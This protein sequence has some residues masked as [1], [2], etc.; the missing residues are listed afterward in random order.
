[1]E[2]S[3][4]YGIDL[5]T[6]HSC[7]S[8]VD[9]ASGRPTVAANAEGEL[10]TPSVVLFEDEETRV[11]GREAKNS[12]TL[13]ADRVVEMVKRQMGVPDWRF[14]FGD[15][16]FS[17]EEISSYI[18]RKVA[19]DTGTLVGGEVRDVV[20]TCPAYFGI[21]ERDATAKAGE[22][23]GLNV[24]EV[25]NEPTAAAISYGVH[26]SEDQVLLVYDLGG[27]TFDVTIIEISGGSITVIATGGDHWLGGRDWDEKIVTH[28]AKAWQEETGSADD[29]LDSEETQ[30]DLWQRAEAAKRALT[31]RPETKVPV[32]HA[33]QRVSVTL[34]REKFD[35]LS[36]SLLNR[37]VEYTKD[38]IA[39]AKELGSDRL[40]KILLVGGST[41]MPQV[42]ERLAEEFGI[43]TVVHEPDQAVAKGAA[44]Y[45]QKLL[46]GERIEIARKKHG[47]EAEAAKAVADDFGM[48]R[49]TVEK[50]AAM[51]VTN[52]ASHSFGIVV[53]SD[54]DGERRQFISNLVFSQD[55]L[56]ASRNKTYYTEEANQPVVEL[57]IMENTHRSELV[58][59][60][61]GKEVGSAVLGMKA[62]LPELA[63]V[64]VTFEL[65]RDGRLQV[66]GRDLS[67]GGETTT[68]KIETNRSLSA[69]EMAQAKSDAKGIKVSG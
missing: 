54:A 22:I 67:E 24:R 13:S 64:E 37:T 53:V 14:P 40:D 26:D 63:P 7:V 1:M 32:S 31:A 45:G 34:T 23:A 2:S 43:E 57:R 48:R 58:D 51:S 44:I 15:R 69:E 61:E 19:G 42:G 41:R 52:V 12:A 33:G 68:A 47:T 20:I 11:V 27:G 28:L 17:P 60:E 55:R 56:P 10:T 18:L 62:G 38:V 4:V 5:G 59:M 3:R 25:I 49:E 16:E 39:T 8:Y 65:Q 50:L 36:R 30:Q 6:T 29:P 46:L 35:E 9:E 66:T 21:S